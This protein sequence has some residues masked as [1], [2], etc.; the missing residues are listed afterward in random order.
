MTIRKASFPL[1]QEER[2]LVFAAIHDR[3]QKLVW[4]PEHKKL[5]DDEM[6]IRMLQHLSNVFDY[7]EKRDRD[8]P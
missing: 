2:R 7:R 3:L 6:N 4:M 5:P 8:R 1:T